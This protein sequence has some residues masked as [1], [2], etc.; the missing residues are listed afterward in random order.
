MHLADEVLD[1][2]F[3]DFDV[4]DDAVAQ[5]TD[6]FD[7]VRGLAHH[8]LRIVTHRLH[9]LDAVQRFDR[10]DRRFVENDALILNI[11]QRVGGAEIDRHV[12]RAELEEIVPEAH[13]NPIP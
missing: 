4:G 13:S 6:R 2:L 9:A 3:G 10:D 5:G 11:N 7:A 12:L 8:H 1:H